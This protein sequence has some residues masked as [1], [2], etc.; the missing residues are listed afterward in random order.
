M[1]NEIKEW[2][3]K[4]S[5]RYQD[6]SNIRVDKVH[7]GPFSPDEDEL[8][9]LGDV[10]GKKIIELGC[11]AGQSSIAFSLK[12]AVCTAVDFSDVQIRRAERLF[13]DN[14]VNIK[15]VLTDITSLNEFADEEY[16]IAFSAFALQFVS[17]LELCF[18]SVYRILRDGGTLV[19]SL[20][21]PFYSIVSEKGVIIKSY[22]ELQEIRI[23]NKAVFYDGDD[24]PGGFMTIYHHTIES[25]F[26][27][28]TNAGFLVERIV[29]PR[30]I[31]ENDPWISMYN[32]ELVR[33][34]GPT[35]I[36]LAKKQKSGKP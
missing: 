19:F 8:N 33:L 16:D 28:L 24:V 11:G 21:H 10:K 4:N 25:I 2:W 26:S 31:S 36:F 9:L 23:D 1:S 35:I 17:D 14:R 6:G 15:T 18:R 27:A 30:K 32:L 12:G 34:L 29:E 7:Y 22:N 20:D 3:N 5:D 13:Q